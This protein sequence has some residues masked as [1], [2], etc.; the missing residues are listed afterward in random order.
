LKKSEVPCIA[1]RAIEFLLSLYKGI[2]RG[3]GHILDVAG[4]FA[5]LERVSLLEDPPLATRAGS[6]SIDHAKRIARFHPRLNGVANPIYVFGMDE[7]AEARPVRGEQLICL[8]P[9]ERGHHMGERHHRPS[10]VGPPSID[11]PRQIGGDS[12]ENPFRR[13]ALVDGSGEVVTMLVHAPAPAGTAHLVG[14][15]SFKM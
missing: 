2:D 14:G 4:H 6:D 15:A 1:K 3:T 7:I 9:G 12:V 11:H 5:R 8:K 13:G 10:L